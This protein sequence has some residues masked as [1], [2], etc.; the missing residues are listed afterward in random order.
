MKATNLLRLI[1]L[2]SLVM[3]FSLAIMPPIFA[4]ADEVQQNLNSV[5]D[6]H[7]QPEPKPEPDSEDESE[8]ASVS[9]SSEDSPINEIDSERT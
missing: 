3:G 1:P 6:Y 2:T 4:Q 7:P 8:P 9:L 5:P